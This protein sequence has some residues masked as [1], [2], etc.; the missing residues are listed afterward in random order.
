MMM[1]VDF[2]PFNTHGELFKVGEQSKNFSLVKNDL[3]EAT[4]ESPFRQKKGS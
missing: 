1:K 4:L 3:S 2:F